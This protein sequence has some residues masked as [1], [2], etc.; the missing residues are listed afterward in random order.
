VFVAELGPVDFS[1]GAWDREDVFLDAEMLLAGSHPF[2]LG[3]Q[4]GDDDREHPTEADARWWASESG[5]DCLY[6]YE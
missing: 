3:P 4:V 6:G 2:P 5:G 1:S